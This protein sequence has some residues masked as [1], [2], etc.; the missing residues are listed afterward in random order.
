VDGVLRVVVAFP[1]MVKSRTSR[2]ER[3]LSAVSPY[4]EIFVVTHDNPDPD[5]IASGWAIVC[6]VEAR[7]HKPVRLIGGGAIVR[8]ENRHMLKLLEP[9]LE[10]V[11]ELNRPANAGVVF[12]DCSSGGQNHLF[13]PGTVVPAAV[14]DHHP[15]RGATC[16]AGFHDI[17]PRAAASASITASYL[18]EQGV[19]PSRKL[20]TALLYAIQTESIGNE[21]YFSRLDRTVHQWLSRFADPAVLAEIENAPLSPEYFADLALALQ[22]T[23]I[24]GDTALCLLPRASGPEIVG[25]VADLLI[26]C[27]GIRRVLCG[28]VFRDDIVLSVRTHPDG[29]DAAALVRNTLHGLG[30][31]GGHR[32]RAG[33]KIPGRGRGPM[34]LELLQDE[35]LTRW[36]IACGIDHQRGHHLIARREIVENL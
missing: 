36:L 18:R 2:S 26:R 29:E 11:R 24:Y 16:P 4:D 19:E 32:H 7:L 9:P 30:Y 10:L 5:A 33:G 12:V 31:G 25:E 28:A 15:P 3:F 21:V 17:R 35:L 34:V 27:E 20:A 8:A 6:L 23:F 14:I 13:P 22:G 1:V